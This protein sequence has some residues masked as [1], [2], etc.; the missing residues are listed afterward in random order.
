MRFII[1]AVLM[2]V[3]VQANAALEASPTDFYDVSKLET[4]TTTVSIHTVPRDNVNAVCNKV[5]S[6]LGKG[7]FKTAVE[8]CAFWEVHNG[9]SYCH[10]IV[11]SRTNND[12][13][14]H[15][16]RHCVQGQFH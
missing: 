12:I 7:R 15:E 4:D 1:A 10:I 5:S 3:A 13:L 11:G 14:G 8:G 9:Q 16:F 6:E 2:L